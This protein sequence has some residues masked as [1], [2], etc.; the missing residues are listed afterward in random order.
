MSD[1]VVVGV[2]MDEFE[3]GDRWLVS[4]KGDRCLME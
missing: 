4:S 1:G 2:A 3:R